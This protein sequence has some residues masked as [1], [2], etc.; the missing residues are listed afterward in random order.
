MSAGS[1]G[2]D[3]HV[4]YFEYS[5]S[6]SPWILTRVEKELSGYAHSEDDRGGTWLPKDFGIVK[7]SEFDRRPFQ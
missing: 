6:T 5:Q 1:G 3:D 7:F 4:F 2:G